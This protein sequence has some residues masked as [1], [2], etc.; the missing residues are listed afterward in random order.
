MCRYA[1]VYVL[2]G[3]KA[4][5]CVAKDSPGLC[6][7]GAY[8]GKDRCLNFEYAVHEDDGAVVRRVIWVVFFVC[9]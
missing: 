7:L 1:I 9:M 6:S 4:I 5:G 2:V 8:D 3:S